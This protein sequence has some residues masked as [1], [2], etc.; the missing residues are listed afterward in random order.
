M[1]D[2]GVFVTVGFLGFLG[3]ILSLKSPWI[4]LL[5]WVAALSIQFELLP[6]LRLALSDLFVPALA[7][8]LLFARGRA[9]EKTWQKRSS[10]PALILFFAAVFLIWGNTVTYF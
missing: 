8:T 6:E 1:T 7:L 2:T 3:L 10:L 9:D 4:S 5:G